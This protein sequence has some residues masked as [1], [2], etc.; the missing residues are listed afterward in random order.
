MILSSEDPAFA[1]TINSVSIEFEEALVQGARGSVVPREAS[2]N[3]D[4][5][6]IY[7]LWPETDGIDSGF[8]RLR[9]TVPESVDLQSVSV[10][11]GSEN[12]VPT[13]VDMRSD[14]LFIDLPQA[15]ARDSIQVSFTT[16][17]LQNATVFTLD[18]G[19]SERPGLWQS[20]EA[21]ERRSNIVMLPELTGSGRLIGDLQV[22][23]EVFTPNGDGVNDRLEVRFVAFK[24][25]GIEPRVEVFDLAGRKI[26]ALAPGAEGSQRL[27]TWDGR[28]ADGAPA[29]P[30]I[31]VLRV[32]LGADAGDDTELRTIAV[33]Y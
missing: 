23:S 21:A 27:F 8:N 4:T 7:T 24:V 11:I 14:S 6:F 19:S 5:R 20:V 29:D 30:G 9:F 10:I 16:R 22:A 15:I 32:D 17:L 1:P 26:A 2:P 18:I 3:Q 12:V 25:E 13:A 33:A 31:Y 28:D